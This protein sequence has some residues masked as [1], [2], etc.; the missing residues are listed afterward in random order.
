MAKLITI[1]TWI[2]SHFVVR[3]KSGLDTQQ[4]QDSRKNLSLGLAAALGMNKLI[5]IRTIHL[6]TLKPDL[7]TNNIQD[8]WKNLSL[9]SAEALGMTK[10]IKIRTMNLVTLKSDLESQQAGL[11][12]QYYKLLT[13]IIPPLV[14]YFSMIL[15]ELR[16]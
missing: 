7:D 2:C 4:I 15:T 12:D 16:Q 14:A 9:S 10:L 1:S 3:L 5:K 11:Y 6:V 8:S 13:A